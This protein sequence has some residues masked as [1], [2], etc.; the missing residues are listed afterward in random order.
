MPLVPHPITCAVC[1]WREQCSRTLSAA[2]LTLFDMLVRRRRVKKNFVLFRHGQVCHSVYAIRGGFFKSS[3]PTPDAHEQVI[4]FPM[5][6]EM[7]AFDGLATGFHACTSTALEDSEVCE[8]SLD[9]LDWMGTKVPT[10]QH[11]MHKIMGQEIARGHVSLRWMGAMTA[12]QR[13]A[14][15]LL[16]L[17]SRF[18]S[19]GFSA[20]E[21]VLPMTREE[22]G[23]LLGLKL[24]TVSRTFSR[25]AAERIL[26]VSQRKIT[27]LDGAALETI[28]QRPADWEAP[29]RRVAIR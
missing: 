25:L 7:L 23:S 29:I 2:D 15:F 5:A 27:I 9:S 16:E 28:A 14:N 20:M 21:L 22:L 8:I 6:G 24:E 17:S 1:R 13:L 26:S 10:L 4:A 3:M 11:D 18:S 12:P 19:R